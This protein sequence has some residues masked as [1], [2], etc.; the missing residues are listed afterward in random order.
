MAQDTGIN[1]PVDFRPPRRQEIPL[2]YIIRDHQALPPNPDQNDGR[3]DSN[4][5]VR[6]EAAAREKVYPASE[7]EVVR[8]T[9]TSVLQ[10][11][12]TN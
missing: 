3:P 8:N 12:A 1:R 9:N 2:G 7:T 6:V 5:R 4:Y 11:V 10:R